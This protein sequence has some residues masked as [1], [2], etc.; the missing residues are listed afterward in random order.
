MINFNYKQCNIINYIINKVIS[1][2][3][4][5]IRILLIFICNNL[6]NLI[7]R[8]VMMSTFL[9]L[10]EVLKNQNRQSNYNQKY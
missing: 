6:S 5:Y 2:K 9:K 4:L 3:F 1:N 8:K 7:I 10:M